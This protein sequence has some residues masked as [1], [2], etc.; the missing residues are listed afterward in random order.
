MTSLTTAENL[1]PLMAQASGGS[2]GALDYIGVFLQGGGVFMLF[3]LLCSLVA[4]TVIIQRAISLRTG[5]ILPRF[6]SRELES[7][8]A[9]DSEREIEALRV[10]FEKRETPLARILASAYDMRRQDPETMRGGVESVAREEVVRLQSGLSI[11]EVVITI[12]PLL[13]LLGTVSGLISVFGVFGGSEALADP[14]PVQI[15]SGI[16]EALYTTIGGLAVAVPVVIAHSYFNKKIERMAARME[17]LVS[18]FMVA[19]TSKQAMHP[20]R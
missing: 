1:V 20:E 2:P 18:H 9:H 5:G 7:L 17:V 19:L 4:V 8:R 15:A 13:G 12:A 16:A 6:L 11:L 10:E 14:D 3:I